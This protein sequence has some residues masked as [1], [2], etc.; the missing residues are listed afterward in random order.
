MTHV[1]EDRNVAGTRSRIRF[2]RHR[3]LNVTCYKPTD[4]DELVPVG[5]ITSMADRDPALT[6]DSN[7]QRHFSQME[8]INRKPMTSI[9]AQVTA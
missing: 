2:A 3:G 5:K 6:V 1:S 9:T 4:R 8:W 7:G